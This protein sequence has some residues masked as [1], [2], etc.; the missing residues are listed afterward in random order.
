MDF[1]IYQQLSSPPRARAPAVRP[2]GP[3]SLPLRAPAGPFT[4]P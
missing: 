1:T 4:G 3:E 2:R